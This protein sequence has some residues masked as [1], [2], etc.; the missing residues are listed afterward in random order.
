MSKPRKILVVARSTVGHQG[1]GGMENIVDDVLRRLNGKDFELSLLTTPGVNAE[2][3]GGIFS[4]VWTIPF[5]RKG[6]YSL[7]WW[8]KTP[9]T[10][11]PWFA[12]DPDLVLSISVGAFSFSLHPAWSDKPIVAQCHGTGWHEVKSSLTSISLRELAK[13]PLNMLRIIRDRVAYR[14]FGTTIAVS[15]NV[16][17]Q[18]TNFPINAQTG[19]VEVITN[20]VD[21]RLWQYS[22][23][24]RSVKRQEL[25]FPTGSPIA[26]YVG[27][28]HFQK[29]TDVALRA[30]VELGDKSWCTVICGDGPEAD[31]LRQLTDELGLSSRVRFTGRVPREEVS[32]LLSAADLM[33]FPTRGYEVPPMNVLEALA[34][35]LPVLTTARASLPREFDHLVQLSTADPKTFAMDWSAMRQ[36]RQRSSRLPAGYDMDSAMTRYSALLSNVDASRK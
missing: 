23:S 9:S 2:A 22:A 24:S 14:R 5:A 26:I 19:R 10:Q 3:L 30:L 25:G 18:L 34:A 11:S 33:V 31:N 17:R 8:W 1:A 4:H 20:A 21:M 27:R 7:L 13:I 16:A 6:K 28:L 32:A 15:P 35:G 12:W 29:G 36:V